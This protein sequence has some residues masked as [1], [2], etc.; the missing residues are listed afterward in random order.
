MATETGPGP[1][2]LAIPEF[3]LVAVMGASE[4]LGRRL[5]A[6]AFAPEE[7]A[8][9]PHGADPAA[10][11]GERAERRLAERRLVAVEASGI[12]RRERG[13]L[14]ALA[15]RH[16]ALPVAILVEP[17]AGGHRNAEALAREGFRRIHR[18][19]DGQAGA[20]AI[21]RERLPV[22]RR[23]DAGPFDLIGDVHGCCEEL[24]ALLVRLGYRV[25]P[26]PAGEAPF[27][28]RHPAGRRAVFL[29]DL[30][31]RG[32]RSLDC[33]RLAMGMVA[34][35]TARAVVGNHDDKLLRWL[36]GHDVRIGGALR[37]T[38]AEIEATSPAF[39]ARLARFLAGLPSHLWLA[40]GRL[41]AV[42]AGLHAGLHGRDTP[43]LRELAMYGLTTGE[44]DADGLPVRIDWA[45]DY[46][47][48]A[49]V[50]Y[51]HTPVAEPV[52]VNRTI[53]IDTG[54]GFGG[55]L[56]AL[57]W[58]ERELVSVPA[59]RPHAARRRPTA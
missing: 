18:L 23:E 43:D 7:V 37:R 34:E 46:D 28:A 17:E 26:P 31:D 44:T 45:R 32:P 58:P 11:I 4:E 33:L 40:G 6:E 25:D 29:G 14:V 53:C 35:G 8:A 56:T 5:L 3:C 2:T 24:E 39:R 50:V 36:E 13:A 9:V 59:A 47:G 30:T 15:R 51:G 21:R 54:C 42:H 55:R 22:D 16:H 49:E 38:I 57:R 1:G 20:A 10:P 27:A 41:V 52:W 48:A 19:E 12:G